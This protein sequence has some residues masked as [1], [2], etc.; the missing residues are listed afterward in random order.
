MLA[1]VFSWVEVVL[2][3]GATWKSERERGQAVSQGGIFGSE[4]LLLPPSLLP[5][6]RLRLVPVPCHP[7]LLG[8]P[9]VAPAPSPG[10]QLLPV[11]GGKEHS[12]SYWW[13]ACWCLGLLGGTG[14]HWEPGCARSTHRTPLW[15]P[16]WGI[17]DFFGKSS[18]EKPPPE[19]R[20]RPRGSLRDFGFLRVS[21][22]LCRWN[23]G[24]FPAPPSPVPLSLQYRFHPPGARS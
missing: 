22:G 4:E 5:L 13:A 10:V 24:G 11:P 21:G 12:G 9:Q 17:S 15:R 3:A 23:G 19:P 7:S 20:V 8:E 2:L 16:H 1:R 14:R 6:Q 18:F